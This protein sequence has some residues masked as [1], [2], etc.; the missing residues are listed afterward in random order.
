[1]IKKSIFKAYDIRGKYPKELNEEAVFEIAS[2]LGRHFGPKSR[3]LVG[4]DGRLSSPSLFKSVLKGLGKDLE[5][6]DGELMT[7]PML[8]FLVNEL[9][10]D[11]GIMVTASHNPKEYNGLKVVGKNARPVS[12]SEILKLMNL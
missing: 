9:K 10:A 7:T 5:I 6:I 12:G 11:G 2:A 4:R 8:Y 3:L 1:M